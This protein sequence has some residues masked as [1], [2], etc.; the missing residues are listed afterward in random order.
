M[1]R[2]LKAVNHNSLPFRRQWWHPLWYRFMMRTALAWFFGPCRGRIEGEEAML[3]LLPEGFILAANHTSYL[4]WMVLHALFHYRHRASLVF[5]AKDSLYRHPLWAPLI[6]ESHS[7][8]VA[9]DGTS[10]LDRGGFRQLRKA[11][12]IGIFPEGTR[13][14]DG[15]PGPARS[16]VASMAARFGKPVI[17][18]S[19]N[20][21]FRTWPRHRAWPRPAQC[22]ITFGQAIEIPRECRH[23][24]ALAAEHTREIMRRIADGIE[25]TAL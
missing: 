24:Q 8:R 20:G 11:R 17:P 7:V 2:A 3:R 15:R 21:F 9:D 22:R 25:E 10:V 4:D 6:T 16:G 1:G 12:L 23:D 14:H 13:S 19:L 5:V 18:A